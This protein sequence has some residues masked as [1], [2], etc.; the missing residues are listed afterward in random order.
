MKHSQLDLR[1]RN[2]TFTDNSRKSQSEEQ[3]YSCGRETVIGR[4][5]VPSL[6]RSRSASTWAAGAGANAPTPRRARAP[7]PGS[8]G[9][10]HGVA[11]CPLVVVVV[12][13][14]GLLFGAV[15]V[16]QCSSRAK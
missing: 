14:S 11:Q 5:T 12:V 8:S 6:H 10:A 13:V 2:D 3:Q 4:L 1:E 16:L 7:G 15:Q 9:E